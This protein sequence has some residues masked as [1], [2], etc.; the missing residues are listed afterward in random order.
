MRKV[1]VTAA[2]LAILTLAACQK[3]RISADDALVKDLA[4]ASSSK[5]LALAHSYGH[6]QDTI[7][8]I[9]RRPDVSV[10][11]SRRMA[12]H[13]MP[14]TART[15]PK[16]EITPIVT[17]A[18]ATAP[19]TLKPRPVKVSYTA[20]PT[21]TN[22]PPQNDNPAAAIWPAGGPPGQGDEGGGAVLRG[23]T[24]DGDHCDPRGAGG[25]APPISINSRIPFH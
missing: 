17:H 14:H 12:L 1:P 8:T 21:A 3:E 16:I 20:P 22:S 15:A 6:A 9:E 13:A 18:L 24:G 7:S 19:L 5:G 10:A 2:M 4:F 23:G 25:G 11:K